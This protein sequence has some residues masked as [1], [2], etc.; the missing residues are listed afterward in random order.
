MCDYMQWCD[1]TTLNVCVRLY[2]CM[3]VCN[4]MYVFLSATF[5][6][7]MTERLVDSLDQQQNIMIKMHSEMQSLSN[8][9]S[10]VLNA[11]IA[12]VDEGNSNLNT[13]AH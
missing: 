6:K 1:N 5:I 7:H 12:C 2:V 11:L 10:A 9:V 13:T 3:Y 4:T 8:D